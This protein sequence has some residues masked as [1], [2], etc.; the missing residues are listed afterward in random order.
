MSARSEASRQSCFVGKAKMPGRISAVTLPFARRCS[1]SRRG[2]SGHRFAACR[3]MPRPM[4]A[5]P[6]ALITPLVVMEI[7]TRRP[8]LRPRSR[9]E[10]R[11]SAISRMAQLPWVL[12]F[13]LWATAQITVLFKGRPLGPYNCH[14]LFVVDLDGTVPN[15]KS[16]LG[17]NRRRCMIDRDFSE[18]L[19][20]RVCRYRIAHSNAFE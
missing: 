19:C 11:S 7:A 8:A 20:W 17:G 5:S 16:A 18:K 9:S 12:G 3:A 15:C 6:L 14:K 4:T 2:N 1:A 10:N 13:G